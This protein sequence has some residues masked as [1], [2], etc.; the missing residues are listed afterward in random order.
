MRG[1][2]YLPSYQ[3]MSLGWNLSVT[4]LMTV[5]FV[6]EEFGVMELAVMVM[7]ESMLSACWPHQA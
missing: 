6:G 3:F 5:G 2:H 4:S 1:F 7:A